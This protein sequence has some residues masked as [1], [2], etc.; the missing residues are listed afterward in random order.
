MMGCDRRN[1]IRA[2][3]RVKT[4]QEVVVGVEGPWQNQ[5]TR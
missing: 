4:G 3:R 5:G 2:H 1:G